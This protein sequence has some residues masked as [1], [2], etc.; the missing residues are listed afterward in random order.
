MS[1]EPVAIVSKETLRDETVLETTL[2]NCV[3]DLTENKIDPPA[4]VVVGDVVYLRDGLDWVGALSGRI[5]CV[6]PLKT[7]VSRNVG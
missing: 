4:I 6:D 1:N 5:L 7:R 3:N 2:E